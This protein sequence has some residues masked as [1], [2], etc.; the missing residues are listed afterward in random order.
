MSNQRFTSLGIE[1]YWI[2]KGNDFPGL[3]I[4]VSISSENLREL[5]L[6]LISEFISD[7]QMI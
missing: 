6:V 5:N 3:D 2:E 4:A 7:I 1:K